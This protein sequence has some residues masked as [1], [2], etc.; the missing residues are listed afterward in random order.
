MM[1]NCKVDENRYVDQYREKVCTVDHF[2]QEVIGVEDAQLELVPEVK[3]LIKELTG[4][5]QGYVDKYFKTPN[6]SQGN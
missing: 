3:E 6:G 4:Q 2:K 5:V 1:S